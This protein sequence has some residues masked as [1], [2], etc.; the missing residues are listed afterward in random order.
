[1]TFCNYFFLFSFNVGYI[2]FKV[3]LVRTFENAYYFPINLWYFLK[4]PNFLQIT[5]CIYFLSSDFFFLIPLQF[6]CIFC[7]RRVLMILKSQPD[8][9]LRQILIFFLSCRPISYTMLIIFYIYIFFFSKTGSCSSVIY[10]AFCS[11]WC[12]LLFF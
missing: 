7:S 12:L 8:L 5:H 10:R 3:K 1:M 9:F 6:L 2:L 4:R 11:K